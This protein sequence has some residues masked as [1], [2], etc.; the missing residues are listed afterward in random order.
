MKKL[1]T[2]KMLR[3]IERLLG[4]QYETNHQLLPGPGHWYD[5]VYW[6]NLASPPYR[7]M[8]QKRIQKEAQ[9]FFKK[10]HTTYTW[11]TINNMYTVRISPLRPALTGYAW[12]YSTDYYMSWTNE[13]ITSPPVKEYYKAQTCL[14]LTI[15]SKIL[16]AG[17]YR[18]HFLSPGLGYFSALEYWGGLAEGRHLEDHKKRIMQR[19]QLYFKKQFIIYT[20]NTENNT[21]RVKIN[22]LRTALT[23]AAFTADDFEISRKFWV[24]RI[25]I[26]MKLAPLPFE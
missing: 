7:E 6:G 22:P 8:H 11:D 23:K 2:T 3:I 12:E 10:R 20:W 9:L 24:N 19:A 17:Y 5:L 16:G 26:S 14:M 13:D 18:N 4:S 15:L 1:Q 25:R 21:Y